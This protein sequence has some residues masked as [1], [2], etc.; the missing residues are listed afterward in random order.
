LLTWGFTQAKFPER[1][2]DDIFATYRD[3]AS[4]N[5]DR[6]LVTKLLQ[7]LCVREMANTI[8]AHAAPAST[9]SPSEAGTTAKPRVLI[10]AVNPGLCRSGLFGNLD[11]AA[12]ML[13]RLGNL[14][15]GRTAEAGSRT[16]VA[17]AIAGEEAQGK[18]MDSCTVSEPSKFVRSEEGK[19]VGKK[20]WEELLKVL[21]GVVPG[22]ADNL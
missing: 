17:G 14:I 21:D 9:I 10:A 15:V 16:I 1:K 6:Y 19:K 4:M 20:V 2:A 3:P 18:Y 7:V 11:P 5:A 8:E 22:V 13:F 12:T